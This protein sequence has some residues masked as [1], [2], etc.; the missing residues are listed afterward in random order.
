M[1]YYYQLETIDPVIM[2]QGNATTNNH[3]CF[4][5]IPGSAILG[6]MAAKHYPDNKLSDDENGRLF[7]PGFVVFQTVTHWC[8]TIKWLCPHPPAGMV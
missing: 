7:R 8:K 6:V 3:N 5:Y 4:D 1:R 2:S